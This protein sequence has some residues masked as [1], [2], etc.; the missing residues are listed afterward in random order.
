MAIVPESAGRNEVAKCRC[1]LG[2]KGIQG[3]AVMAD[4]NE[5]PE[6]IE[7]SSNHNHRGLVIVV[8]VL[9]W[10][11]LSPAPI[12][13]GLEKMG[14]YDHMEQVYFIFYAPLGYLANRFEFISKFYEWQGRLFDL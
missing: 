13:W 5:T 12:A 10:Y 7:H 9:A 11:V 4:E 14:A 6:R 3:V 2:S 8:V 1:R